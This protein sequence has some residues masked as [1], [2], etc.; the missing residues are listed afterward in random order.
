MERMN[1]L[2]RTKNFQTVITKLV[3]VSYIQ[4]HQIF[5]GWNF[6]NFTR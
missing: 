2:I 3:Q 6:I 4:I 5:N 1:C